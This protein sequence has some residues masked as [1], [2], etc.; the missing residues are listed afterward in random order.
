[1]NTSRRG[2]IYKLLGIGAVFSVAKKAWSIEPNAKVPA[3]DSAIGDTPLA[4]G[5]GLDDMLRHADISETRVI[6]PSG[7][8]ALH[9]ALNRR[10]IYID[11]I[12]AMLA[13]DTK[14]LMHGQQ[15]TVRGYHPGTGIGGGTFH[16]DAESTAAIDDG[17]VFGNSP[18]GRFERAVTG[19]LCATDFGAIPEDKVTGSD[20][21]SRMPPDEYLIRYDICTGEIAWKGDG[22]AISTTPNSTIT[23]DDGAGRFSIHGSRT[24]VPYINLVGRLEI[25]GADPDNRAVGVYVGVAN[26]KNYSSSPAFRAQWASEIKIQH[27]DVHLLGD[28]IGNQG[29]AFVVLKKPDLG[30][31]HVKG[32]ISLGYQFIGNSTVAEPTI[33]G[34]R[35]GT[36]IADKDDSYRGV[37]NGHH[38]CYLK[39]CRGLG[40]SRIEVYGNGA[41]GWKTDGEYHIKLRDNQ[42]C[43]F[44]SLYAYDS[45]DE[46]GLGA[47]FITSDGN[48]L[49]PMVENYGNCYNNVFGYTDAYASSPG[50]NKNCT[51]HNVKGSFQI[52]SK[53]VL[54]WLV[55][56]K[57]SFLPSAS[58]IFNNFEFNG[59]TVDIPA[60]ENNAWLVRAVKARNSIFLQRLR[61]HNTSIDYLD[62]CQIKGDVELDSTYGE[63]KCNINNS[64]ASGSLLTNTYGSR[65]VVANITN[66]H[67]EGKEASTSYQPTRRNY[68]YVS[69]EDRVYLSENIT[70][71]DLSVR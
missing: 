44:D 11:C 53:D 52:S 54:G 58:Q 63:Y 71:D 39:G 47:I 67:F 51:I 57:Y 65:E 2:F 27:V 24:K 30:F 50:V 66:T 17:T 12:A 1:M 14:K 9:V 46:H 59:C 19:L 60:L 29:V 43:I 35:I 25:G 48:T 36:L 15:V 62:S 33:D 49:P 26:I 20:A 7:E 41:H 31:F 56:G 45:Q 5:Y 28:D 55:T 6:T 13:L 32:N 8:Q 37:E 21:F 18:R 68:R 34:G 40:V 22:Y 3:I 23:L 38:G 69:F 61:V 64:L 42:A 10:V 16:W 4:T 70:T